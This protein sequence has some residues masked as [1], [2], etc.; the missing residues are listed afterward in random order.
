MNNQSSFKVYDVPVTG[1]VRSVTRIPALIV[2][3]LISSPV[4]SVDLGCGFSA[5]PEAQIK[6]GCGAG[7]RILYDLRATM[8]LNAKLRYRSE[9]GAREQGAKVKNIYTL[10]PFYC[11]QGHNRQTICAQITA[12]PDLR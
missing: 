7:L 1:T 12:E 8:I 2:A 3:L 11:Y 5:I 4:L 9:M 6:R 10:S